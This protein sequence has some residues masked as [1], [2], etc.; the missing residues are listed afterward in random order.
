MKRSQD[1]CALSSSTVPSSSTE[2]VDGTN[3]Y[4][5]NG[6]F[7]E[8][9][10]DSSDSEL[11]EEDSEGDEDDIYALP[12]ALLGDDNCLIISYPQLS[13]L[14]YPCIHCIRIRGGIPR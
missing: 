9:G 5:P 12:E 11:S 6:P 1:S 7:E 10:E 13:I 4:D 3:L 2:E 8:F 14:T